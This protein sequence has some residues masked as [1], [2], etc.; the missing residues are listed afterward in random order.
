[1]TDIILPIL[2]IAFILLALVL[3]LV[4]KKDFR[5]S[6]G[7]EIVTTLGI[8]GTF[9]GISISLFHLGSES[10]DIVSS[11]PDF[12]SGLKFAFIASTFGVLSALILR[13]TQYFSDKKEKND[14]KN[15]TLF[16]SKDEEI[17]AELR[18]L[19]KGLVGSE[20]GTLLTQMK[21][22]RQEFNDQLTQLRQSFN[23]FA[24]HMVENN[25]KAFIEALNKAINDFNKNLTDQFGENFKQL[26]VA[27]EKLVLW[28]QQYKEQLEILILEEQK[29]STSMVL[30][31]EAYRD[32]VSN[33]SVFSK[34]ANDLAELL[35]NMKGMTETLFVQSK[36]LSEVLVT[37]K[38]VTPQFESKVD[39]MLSQ[40]DSGISKLVERITTKVEEE[41]SNTIN[42]IGSNYSTIVSSHN[43]SIK[44]HTA[45]VGNITNELKQTLTQSLIEHNLQVN[46][47]VDELK[48]GY[49]SVVAN[50]TDSVRNFTSTIQSSTSEL[51]E[52][53]TGV[54]QN[55]QKILNAGLEDS[56]AKIR[57]GVTTLDK[58]LETELT[59]A[60]ESLSH[61]LAS[62]SAKFVED[63]TPLTDKLREI[64]RISQKTGM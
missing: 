10:K 39:Q 2:F 4:G 34:V 5:K 15:T 17:I 58:G 54:I 29:T 37:M 20:E 26:N 47:F 32:L 62:L 44:S 18:N 41:I 51:K 49:T 38:E 21:L 23:N 56:L 25:Q 24:Q 19:N 35:P 43:E 22:Q 64:V 28:Q 53:L 59:R 40:L 14:H 27:V 45:N 30:A 12:I 16:E 31:S 57:E 9:I 33:S 3:I 63:Y 42:E 52:L 13:L 55:N 36:S 7:T 6:Y 60:L 8:L 1:M 11:L 61:Q 46:K 48:Q 50:H